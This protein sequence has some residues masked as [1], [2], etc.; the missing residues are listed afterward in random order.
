MMGH[1]AILWHAPWHIKPNRLRRI[2]SSSRGI[3]SS[4]PVDI[5]TNHGT[6]S[7][8][9]GCPTILNNIK[10]MYCIIHFQTDPD[11]I[12]VRHIP[13]HHIILSDIPIVVCVCVIISHFSHK[14]YYLG[15]NALLTNIPSRGATIVGYLQL[16]HRYLIYPI[17]GFIN[18]M[19]T[20]YAIQIVGC[21]D[22]K[23][24]QDIIAVI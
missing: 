20:L 5:A 3:W 23:T 21:Y 12:L 16:S 1:N 6:C 10:N 7:L 14:S 15:K 11:R 24:P 4:D 22:S 18:P 2:H 19:L 17:V 9:W 8:T 13:L